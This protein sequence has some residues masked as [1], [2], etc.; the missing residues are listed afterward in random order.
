MPQRHHERENRKGQKGEDLYDEKLWGNPQS[1]A[2]CFQ[3]RENR[4]FTESAESR[5]TPDTLINH[6]I[7]D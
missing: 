6:H 3:L 2:P 4:S 5:Y 1:V 7:P